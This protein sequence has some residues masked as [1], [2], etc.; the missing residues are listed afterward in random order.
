MY[1][2]VLPAGQY[3]VKPAFEYDVK[4]KSFSSYWT[5]CNPLTIPK[6]VLNVIGNAIY[7]LVPAGIVPH[8]IIKW[9]FNI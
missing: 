2:R 6:Q 4:P 9:S 7:P 5:P 3:A 1:L 8:W